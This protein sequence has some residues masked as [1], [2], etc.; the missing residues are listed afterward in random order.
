MVYKPPTLATKTLTLLVVF[1]SGGTFMHTGTVKWFSSAKG[2]G[3]ICCEDID[4]DVFVHYNVIEMEG[5]RTLS[6]NQAV[7]FELEEGRSGL[8]A[9]SVRVIDISEPA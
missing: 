2:F 7:Q 3:F 6:S 5:F 9:K 1:I 8:M 4:G